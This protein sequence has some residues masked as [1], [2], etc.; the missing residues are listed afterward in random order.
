M[1]WLHSVVTS[2]IPSTG[3]RNDVRNAAAPT[4][5]PNSIGSS[6][7]AVT[8]TAMISAASTSR[9][10]VTSSQKPARVS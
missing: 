1:R 4:K 3:S 8:A 9:P 2:M 6:W 5:S 10:I 7:T